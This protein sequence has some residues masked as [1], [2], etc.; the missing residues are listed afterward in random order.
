MTPLG[1][2]ISNTCFRYHNLCKK[3]KNMVKLSQIEEYKNRKKKT[4]VFHCAWGLKRTQWGILR[5]CPPLRQGSKGH[6]PSPLFGIC[7]ASGCL[8]LIMTFL[9]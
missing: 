8:A 5:G 1:D 7:A 2:I 3:Y 9:H 6:S 4:A